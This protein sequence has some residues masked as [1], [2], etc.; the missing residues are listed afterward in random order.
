MRVTKGHTGNRRG[1]H[2]IVMPRLSI[3]S[4]CGGYHERHRVCLECG[5]YKGK[6]VFNVKN[7]KSLV[8]DANDKKSNDDSKKATNKKIETKDKEKIK[9]SKVEKKVQRRETNK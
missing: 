5:F 2:G 3:C 7:K 9:E 4:N 6:Q 8:T 1:H